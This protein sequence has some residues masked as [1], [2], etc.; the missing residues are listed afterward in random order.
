MRLD[1]ADPEQA[2]SVRAELVAAR[3]E[4]LLPDKP[5]HNY[6]T[7]PFAL[8]FP[9]G[10]PTQPPATFDHASWATCCDQWRSGAVIVAEFPGPA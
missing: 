8:A 1:M 10:P 7:A 5:W 2:E 6:L 4:R 9:D 3:L